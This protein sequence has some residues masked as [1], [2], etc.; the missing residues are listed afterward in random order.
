[1]SEEI[2]RF[3]RH[4]QKLGKIEREFST[5]DPV[6]VRAALF[7]LLHAGRVNAPELRTHPLSLLT[8]FEAAEV[9]K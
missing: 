6:L 5:G 7:C 2:E 4:P 9:S 1:M 8:H 3:V